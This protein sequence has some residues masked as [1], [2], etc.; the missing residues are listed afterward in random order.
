MDFSD[1]QFPS[2][3]ELKPFKDTCQFSKKQKGLKLNGE[4]PFFP[5]E[6]IPENKIFVQTSLYRNSDNLGSGTF[7][8][9][10]DV[11]VAKI[12]PSF[13]NGKQAIINIKEPYGYATTE[14][15]AFSELNGISDK[16]FLFYVLK[17]SNVRSKLAGQMEGSTGRQRLR[18]EVLGNFLIPLPPLEEQKKIASIL[19]LIQEAIQQ[20]ER[21]ISLTT[22]LKKSL[23]QKLFTEGLNNEP[24]KMTDIGLIPESW[25]VL[26]LA[27]TGEVVYGIQASVANNIEPI[28]TKILTNKN[29]TLEGEFDLEK[30]NYFELTTKR[31]Y[32]TILQQGDILFNWRSGSKDHVGKTAYFNLEGE[33]THSSFILRIRPYQEVN[34]KYLFYYLTR[35]RESNYFVKLQS[36]SVNA[37]FNK[38]A[39]NALPTILPKK[40]EQDK[41]A[42][43]IDKVLDKLSQHRTKLTILQ[44]LF[45]TLLHQLMTAQIRVDEL[46]LTALENQIKEVR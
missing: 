37:K 29:I 31:H 18:K 32:E 27:K 19:T 12:T 40:E 23:M 39:V 42:L 22:E 17:H 8:N 9:N 2:N 16:F 21:A 26:P 24:Q 4:I 14:V 28:G 6:I 35:L 43:S 38:S 25:E 5:M 10:G 34:G 36:F 1:Y 30:V 13:E 41:I 3:W 44:D 7:V 15:I 46:D 33:Y 45:R 20:Q 11:V